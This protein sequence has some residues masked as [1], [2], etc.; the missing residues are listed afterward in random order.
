M[1]CQV[2]SRHTG[3]NCTGTYVEREVRGKKQNKG[4]AGKEGKGSEG[5]DGDGGCW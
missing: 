5:R 2:R 3:V 1:S 4:K